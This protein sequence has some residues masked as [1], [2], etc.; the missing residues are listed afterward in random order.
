M[1]DSWELYQFHSQPGA[2]HQQKLIVGA[3]GHCEATA[4]FKD[5][6]GRLAL[7]YSFEET[8]RIF[9]APFLKEIVIL[10]AN[11]VDIER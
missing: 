9:G 5:L 10:N 6:Y 1:L 4:V 7:V 3:R 11:F 2:R 8:I